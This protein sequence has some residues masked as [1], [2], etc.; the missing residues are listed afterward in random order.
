MLGK[1]S[2]P[3]TRAMRMVCLGTL[4]VSCSRELPVQPGRPAY[5]T[6]NLAASPPANDDFANA[7]PVAALPFNGVVDI[8]AATL[9]TGEPFTACSNFVGFATRTA[10]YAFTPTET[11]WVG[12]THDGTGMVVAYTGSSLFDLTELDCE[13]FGGRVAFHAQAGMTYFVQV[14]DVFQ[15]GTSVVLHLAAIAPPAND[16]F[17]GATAIP[18]PLPFEEIVDVTAASFEDGEPTPSCAFGPVSRTAWY[19]FTPAVSRSVAVSYVNAQFSAVIATYSGTSL[20]TLTS[21]GCSAGFGGRVLL[22]AEAGTTYH[23]QVGGQFDQ[24]GPMDIRLDVLPPP[25]AGIGFFPGD[26]AVFDAIQF[27]DQSFDPGGVGIETEQWSFG[28]GTTGSGCCPTHQYSADADFTVQLTVSTFDGRTAS[29]LQTLRVRTHDVVITKLAVPQTG[30][31]GQTRRI[32]VDVNSKRYAETVEVQLSKSVPG[33][34]Q[35]FG[36]LTQFVPM[37]P[38][39]GTTEFAFSYTFTSDDAQI[40]KVTFRAIA[41]LAGAREAFPSDN[42][43]IALPTKVTR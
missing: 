19:A 22:R 29:T 40:G 35:Q 31:T 42:E 4:A 43:A 24:A 26:P 13:P 10:W 21:L 3:L 30:R 33:G 38:K 23:I 12:A 11:V 1:S 27:F 34:F 14:R 32:V 28:D 41:V 36:S 7:M 9:E 20:S 5:T 37:N 16:A 25:V 39:G 2:R 17:A 15:Q 8:T 6:T 18:E